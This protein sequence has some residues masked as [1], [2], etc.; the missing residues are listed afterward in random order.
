M[1]KTLLLM[2][3]VIFSLTCVSQDSTGVQKQLIELRAQRALLSEKMT[4]LNQGIAGTQIL[5]DSS[6]NRLK[7]QC[8][9]NQAKGKNAFRNKQKPGCN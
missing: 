8:R 7:E 6:R 1:K 3:T 5:M 2:L 9:Q 4:K